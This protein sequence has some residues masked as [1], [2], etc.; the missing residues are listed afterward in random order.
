METY[1]RPE[2]LTRFK[3]IGK[4]SQELAEKFFDYY[5]AVFAEGEL[6]ER[7]KAL[8]ALA[9]A[10]TIQCPYCIDAFTQACLEKGSNLAEMTEAVHVVTAIRGGASLVHGIQ[11]RNIAEKLSI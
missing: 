7:E 1:Y 8:I 2:D 11:M 3:E 9:V 4:E 5:G 6:T 10:H